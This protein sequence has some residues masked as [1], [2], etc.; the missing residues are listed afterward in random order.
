QF[1]VVRLRYLH[2]LGRCKCKPTIA[3]NFWSLGIALG[4]AR[5]QLM[6]GERRWQ[7][8]SCGVGWGRI[9]VSTLEIPDTL[10]VSEIRAPNL[11]DAGHRWIGSRSSRRGR[12]RRELRDGERRDSRERPPF[13]NAT[14]S[15][16][17]FESG[18]VTDRQR[19]MLE[20]FAKE[21]IIREN[22]MFAEGIR[23]QQI[24]ER[25]L[26]PKLLLQFS[27]FMLIILLLNKIT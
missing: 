2:C 22:D 17:L 9:G 19:A 3:L 7:L 10:T 8:R 11:G 18:T 5:R 4:R 23:W 16:A 27:F 26:E 14:C 6:L 25:L 1:L 20:E 21:E 13:P 24:V 12:S 15:L